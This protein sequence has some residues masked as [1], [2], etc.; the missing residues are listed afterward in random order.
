MQN[1]VSDSISSTSTLESIYTSGKYLEWHPHWHI[2]ESAWKAAQILQM[3]GKHRLEPQVVT[4]VGCG[5]GE[6]L[7]ELQQKIQGRRDFYGY[8]ISPQAVE[9]AKLR[10][11]EHLHFTA[12]DIRKEYAPHADL[13]LVMDVL[14]HIEDRFGFLRDIRKK[15]DYKLFHVSLTV[16]VQTVLRKRGLLSVREQYGM[17]NYYTKESLL[18]NLRDAGYEIVDYRYTTGSTDLPSREIKRNLMRLPRKMLFAL[19]QDFAAR[20]LGGYRMLILAR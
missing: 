3:L 16:S 20:V 7:W 1:L 2:E 11:N 8:D 4:E 10:E 14:E 19:H 9:R 18:Q 13:V 12:G 6:I 5:V 15:G 17:V